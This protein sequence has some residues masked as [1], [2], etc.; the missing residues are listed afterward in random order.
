M[1]KVKAS[2]EQSTFH[3]WNN[4]NDEILMS[5]KAHR[6]QLDSSNGNTTF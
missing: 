6:K 5:M 3:N 1:N 2:E 4:G